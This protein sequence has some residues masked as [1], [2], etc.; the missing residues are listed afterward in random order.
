MVCSLLVERQEYGLPLS[1]LWSYIGILYLTSPCVLLC[2]EHFISCMVIIL[3]LHARLHTTCYSCVAC[4]KYVM[5]SL[6]AWLIRG[7]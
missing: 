2:A 5:N 6:F 3:E 4:Y 1:I 7:I